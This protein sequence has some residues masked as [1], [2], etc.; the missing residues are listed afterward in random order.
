VDYHIDIGFRRRDGDGCSVC[1]R[2]VVHTVLLDVWSRW[3]ASCLPILLRVSF[4]LISLTKLWDVIIRQCMCK[5]R[6][7]HVHVLKSKSG[8]KTAITFRFILQ[9]TLK[10][11]IKSHISDEMCEQNWSEWCHTCHRK[12]GQC[13][14]QIN[15]NDSRHAMFIHVS[16]WLTL[17]TGLV[18]MVETFEIACGTSWKSRRRSWIRNGEELE[19]YLPKTSEIIHMPSI[20]GQERRNVIRPRHFS[21]R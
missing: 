9:V 18:H 10:W 16:N 11:Q 12:S 1:G 13:T 6:T 17:R 7:H 3:K 20:A 4:G 21:L 2:I 5:G 8:C 19:L 14:W 15:L